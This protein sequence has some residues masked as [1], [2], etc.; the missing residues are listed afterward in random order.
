[1]SSTELLTVRQQLA[2]IW[3]NQAAV[4]NK[5]PHCRF[6][7][8]NQ[9]KAFTVAKGWL[10][11]TAEALLHHRRRGCDADHH[12]GYIEL[13]GVLQAVFIQQDALSEMHFAITGQR[14]SFERNGAVN[15]MKL[16]D[17]RNILVG[18]PTLKDHN[19]QGKLV[20][21]VIPRQ[22][23]T[24]AA[25]QYALDEDDQHS[26]LTINLGALLDAYDTEAAAILWPL[27]DLLKARF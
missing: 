16:R 24:Y 17:L 4:C 1:M 6:P 22:A 15:S 25:I 26:H 7:S 14:K 9:F 18:H 2:D 27:L 13:Y 12:Q 5:Q 3:K 21:S 23:M 11:D 8:A 19:T 10:Q 20:R